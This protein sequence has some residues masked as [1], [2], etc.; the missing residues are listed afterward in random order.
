MPEITVEEVKMTVEYMKVNWA[1]SEDVVTFDM[2]KHGN[3]DKL[4]QISAK[5]LCQC[6][7]TSEIATVCTNSTAVLEFKKEEGYKPNIAFI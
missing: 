6:L 4:I 5:C 3:V 2:I 7:Q 1:F